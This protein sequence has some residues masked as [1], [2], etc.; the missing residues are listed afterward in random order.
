MTIKKQIKELDTPREN[1]IVLAKLLHKIEGGKNE[2]VI[3][4]NGYSY[5]F[6]YGKYCGC[7]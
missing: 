4:L 5:F 6:K 1:K 2:K 7:R 3:Y